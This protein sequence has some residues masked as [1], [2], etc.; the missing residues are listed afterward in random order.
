M[1]KALGT[2]V[3]AGP[4][5]EIGWGRLQLTEV[6]LACCLKPLADDGATVQ[7]CHADTFDLATEPTRLACNVNYENQAFAFGLRALAL[8][9]HAEADPRLLEEWYVSHAVELSVAGVSLHELWAATAD[10]AGRL[11]TQAHRIF[12]RWLE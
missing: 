1:A 5:K 12:C 11:Q 3:F 10:L 2:R 9:F 4:M 6:G 7:H 8:Q